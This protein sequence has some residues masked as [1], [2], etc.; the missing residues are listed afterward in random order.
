MLVYYCFLFV[1]CYSHI[2]IG[3]YNQIGIM[4]I[5]Y[6]CYFFRKNRYLALDLHLI[7]YNFEQYFSQFMKNNTLILPIV[8]FFAALSSISAQEYD[9]RDDYLKQPD[10]LGPPVQLDE[11]YVNAKEQKAN[12]E[13]LRVYLTLQRRVYRVYPYAKIAA[14]R[15]TMLNEGMAVLKTNRER[16][17]YFKIVESYLTNEF[18]KQLKNLSSKDGKI[19]VRLIHRQTGKTTY[20]LIH[21]LKSGWKAFWSNNTAKLFDINLKSQYDPIE[22]NEDYFIETILNRAFASGRLSNQNP[23]IVIDY[24]KI[25]DHW[26]EKLAKK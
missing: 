7:F 11:V 26:H 15:L 25:S 8:L 14:E 13:A 21:D 3:V 23:G 10:T 1:I 24:E 9:K 5:S 19:L 16:N 6:K 20:Q 4:L 18:E 22:S 2:F 12:A 17:K